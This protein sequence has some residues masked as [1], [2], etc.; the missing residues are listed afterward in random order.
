MFIFTKC[1]FLLTGI[2]PALDWNVL[3]LGFMTPIDTRLDWRALS[4]LSTACRCGAQAIDRCVG[5]GGGGDGGGGDGGGDGGNGDGGNGDGSGGG[6]G[7][8]ND[9]RQ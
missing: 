4:S 9:I 3:V 1:G 6:S 7:D 8:G 2:A 5:G